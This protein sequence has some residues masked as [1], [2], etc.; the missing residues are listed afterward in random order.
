MR[1]SVV[2][3][4][5]IMFIASI[6]VVQ[7]R[8]DQFKTYITKIEITTYDKIVGDTKYLTIDYVGSNDTFVAIRYN[9]TPDVDTVKDAIKFSISGNTYKD[10]E[11]TTHTFADIKPENGILEFFEYTTRAVTITIYPTDGGA[12]S[13][14]RV[15][16]MLRRNI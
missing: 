3:F 11:G 4:I 10:E 12:A 8:I 14:D 9:I 16:V 7:V 15:V 2:F 6:V 13:P 5:S 1:K